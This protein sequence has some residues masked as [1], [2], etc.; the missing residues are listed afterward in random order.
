METF[1]PYLVIET[2]LVTEKSISLKDLNKYMFKVNKYSSK[3]DIARAIEAIYD[4]KVKDVNVFIKPSKPKR[5][6]TRSMKQGRTSESKR[7]IIT[8]REG[9]IELV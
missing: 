4:V 2:I 9:K 1:N 6:G 7:A 5:L 3:V 8:L